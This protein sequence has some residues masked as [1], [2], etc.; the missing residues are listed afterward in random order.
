M[1]E[2]FETTSD[3][4]ALSWGRN[5]KWQS[6]RD[7]LHM[8]KDEKDEFSWDEKHGPHGGLPNDDYVCGAELRHMTE[9]LSSSF[10]LD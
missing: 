1:D 10:P 5:E 3:R 8:G 7:T 2:A 6:A 4:S 9:K